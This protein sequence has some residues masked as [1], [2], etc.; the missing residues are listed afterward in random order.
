MRSNASSVA[1]RTSSRGTNKTFSGDDLQVIKYVNE[2]G[3]HGIRSYAVGFLIRNFTMSLW[4][5]DH[6]GLVK[7]APFN[8]VQ[9]AH[10]LVYF[11]AAVTS[12]SM[13]NMGHLSL[14]EFPPIATTDMLEYYRGVTLKLPKA[15]DINAA[16]SEDLSFSL[17]VEDDNPLTQTYGV[18]GRAT[19]V[20]PVEAASPSAHAA[21]KKDELVMK[22]SWQSVGRVG[23]DEQIRAVRTGLAANARTKRFVAN[24]VD[25]K[26]SLTR[27]MEEMGLPRA[28]MSN[29]ATI[30]VRVCR[31]LILKRYLPL[32]QVGSAKVFK[33][34]FVDVVRG[35]SGRVA[36]LD[37]Y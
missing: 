2:L 24:I 34:V 35:M 31:V 4:Y 3:S 30:D 33:K 6:M 23:E 15:Y 37:S 1:S 7:S 13:R 10:F 16:M 11:L 9:D 26:C 12:A 14:L 18:V 36:Q 28:K 19:V 8:F 29:M 32:E 5:I 17:N 27:T 21:C 20:A 22:V 25:M